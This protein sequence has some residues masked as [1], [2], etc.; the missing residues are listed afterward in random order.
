LTTF[1]ASER[2]EP[3]RGLGLGLALARGKVVDPHSSEIFVG[4][5]R[6]FFSCHGGLWRPCGNHH[7][8]KQSAALVQ[9]DDKT[10]V[11]LNIAY[12]YIYI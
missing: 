6:P 9:R 3:F 4:A 7:G 5:A 1:L 2:P 12:L 8:A 11:K 10:Q